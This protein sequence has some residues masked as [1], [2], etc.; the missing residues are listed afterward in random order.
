MSQIVKI[1][2]NKLTNVQ[3][4]VYDCETNLR[5]LH[6]DILGFY[7][8]NKKFEFKAQNFKSKLDSLINKSIEEIES[9]E[10]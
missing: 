6:W 10:T 9:L 1:E 7:E 8:E 3:N 4:S 5:N 2:E